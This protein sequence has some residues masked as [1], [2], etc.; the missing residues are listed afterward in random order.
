MTIRTAAIVVIAATASVYLLH[1]GAMLFV[2]ALLSVLLAYALEPAVELLMRARLPRILAVAVT[3]SVIAVMLG[4]VARRTVVEF[5]AFVSD[6]PS[7]VRNVQ[8]T[9]AQAHSSTGPT[10]FERLQRAGTEIEQTAGQPPPPPDEGV[11]RVAPVAHRFDVRAYAFD[12]GVATVAASGKLLGVSF[13]TFLLLCTGDLFKQK[14]ITLGGDTFARR[15]LTAEV[16]RAIDRQIQR[17]LVARL[18]ISAI[19]AAATGVA[20]AF[21]GVHH[22]VVWGIVAGV[23]NVLPFVGPSVAVALISGAAFLQFHALTP[24]VIAWTAATAVAVL[25]GNLI[26]PWLTSRAGEINTVAVFASVLFWGWMWDMWGL[27]L[28]IPIMV[29]IKAASDHIEPLQPV[30]ELLGR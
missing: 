26:T 30:S 2:P 11:V 16:I 17:Y 20:L 18:A 7:A 8:Q 21:V 5:N 29:A 15:K 13:L 22:A 25:E 19:V 1:V 9:V 23:L 6:L 27:L 28:A 3:F 14:L 10:V 24:T 12:A 4:T